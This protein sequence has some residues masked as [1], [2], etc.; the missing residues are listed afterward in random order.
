MKYVERLSESSPFIIHKKAIDLE[1]AREFIS[2][3][4]REEIYKE[5]MRSVRPRFLAIGES[6]VISMLK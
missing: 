1:S 2:M 3:L 5:Q 6:L 4:R